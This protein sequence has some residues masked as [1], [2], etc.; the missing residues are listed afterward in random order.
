MDECRLLRAQ[1]KAWESEFTQKFDRRPTKEDIRTEP[2]IGN[3]GDC[4]IDNSRAV[5]VI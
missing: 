5:P 1:L 4:S 3:L 2:L